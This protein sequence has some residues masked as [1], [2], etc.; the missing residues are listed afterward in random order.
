MGEITLDDVAR[1]CIMHLRVVRRGCIS[2]DKS[3][4][5]V[6]ES[7][8]AF[9][10]MLY[11]DFDDVFL[12]SEGKV[13]AC[14]SND[15]SVHIDVPKVFDASLPDWEQTVHAEAKRRE[16]LGF[17]HLSGIGAHKEVWSA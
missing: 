4:C 5:G 15:R 16:D 8:S 13:D 6:R 10:C 14:D 3:I 2:F 12:V 11:N 17:R 9:F 7:D 1:H